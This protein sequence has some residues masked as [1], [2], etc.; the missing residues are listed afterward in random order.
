MQAC[1]K[2]EN[3]KVEMMD[4]PIPEPNE[5]EIIVKTTMATVCGSDMHF[6]DE[7][8]NAILANLDPSAGLP[9]G[10]PMG[11]E[12]VGTVHSVGAGV[13]RF[14]PGERVVSSCAGSATSA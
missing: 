6:V 3:G 13:T 7:F 4:L 10:F 5:G 14:Q 11:H 2:T 9:Q 12:G 8:P 1:I